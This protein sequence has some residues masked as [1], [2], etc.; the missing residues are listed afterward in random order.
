[1]SSSLLQK[2]AACGI[3]IE[4]LLTKITKPA[5]RVVVLKWTFT[6]DLIALGVQSVGNAANA[7]YKLWVAPE[8]KLADSVTDIGTRSGPNL[9]A[10]AAL[11]PDLIISNA[12]NNAAIY[13][14]LKGIALTIEYDPFKG[15]GYEQMNYPLAGTTWTFGG[16]ISSK[17]LVDQVVGS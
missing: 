14:Q 12:D 4:S 2:Y 6:E 3:S 13:A 17:V 15:N 10:I 16:P 11:K 8:A 9:E 1:M 5:E 7:N